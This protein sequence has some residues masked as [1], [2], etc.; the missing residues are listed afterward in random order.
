MA[1]NINTISPITMMTAHAPCVNLV[2]AM[3][4]KTTNVTTAPTPLITA[5]TSQLLSQPMHYHS[6]LRESKRHENAERIKRKHRLFLPFEDDY[7]Q[8][9]AA[10]PAARST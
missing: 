5:G 9:R 4:I 6:R 1:R 8:P 10:D 2:T 7:K 3:T